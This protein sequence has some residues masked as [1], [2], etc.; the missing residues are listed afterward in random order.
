M[1]AQNY[2]INY[3]IEYCSRSIKNSEM[4]KHT[5]YKYKNCNM[6]FTLKYQNRIFAYHRP[7]VGHGDIVVRTPSVGHIDVVVRTRQW[8]TV[9]SWLEHRQWG[10]VTSWLEHCQWAR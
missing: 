1:I 8:G 10:T 6:K 5:I 7:S 3:N 2:L 9:T 4:F